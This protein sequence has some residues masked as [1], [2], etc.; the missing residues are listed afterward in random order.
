V[1]NLVRDREFCLEPWMEIIGELRSLSA[2]D[3]YISLGIDEKTISFRKDSLEELYIQEK[4]TEDFIGQRIS[5]LRTNIP[6]R[7]ILVFVG[8]GV[9][10]E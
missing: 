5:V 6:E 1:T 2:D 7:P 8:K 3:K 10:V 4:V 9:A